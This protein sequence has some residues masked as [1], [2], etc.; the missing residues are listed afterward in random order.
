[1]NKGKHVE[2]R[3]FSPFLAEK[4]AEIDADPTSDRRDRRMEILSHRVIESEYEGWFDA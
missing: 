2:Y 3:T 4:A 1:M